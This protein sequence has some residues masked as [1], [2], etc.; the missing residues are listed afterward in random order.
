MFFLRLGWEMMYAERAE[1]GGLSASSE[2]SSESGEKSG[3]GE[4]QSLD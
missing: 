1:T 4:M 2:S 3:K